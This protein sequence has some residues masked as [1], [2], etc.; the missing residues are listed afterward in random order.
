VEV[1]FNVLSGK[2]T[3]VGGE[4]AGWFRRFFE[5]KPWKIPWKRKKTKTELESFYPGNKKLIF[6]K[7]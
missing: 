2:G 6:Q 1:V 7:P 4:L 3:E 5:K